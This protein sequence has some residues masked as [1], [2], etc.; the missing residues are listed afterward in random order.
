MARWILASLSPT[1]WFGA[2]VYRLPPDAQRRNVLPALPLALRVGSTSPRADSRL[3]SRALPTTRPTA[4]QLGSDPGPEP[5]FPGIPVAGIF[6]G[7]PADDL[8]GSDR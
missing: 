1:E 4:C 2:K 6:H 7:N 8:I 3:A 5:P